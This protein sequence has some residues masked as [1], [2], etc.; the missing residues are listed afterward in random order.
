[1][2]RFKARDQ[3][4]DFSQPTPPSTTPSTCNA[5]SHRERPTGR[6]AR[7]EHMAR[8]FRHGLT[9]SRSA[10]RARPS[11]ENVTT[12]S[13]S[14]DGPAVRS[15]D[16]SSAR[17]TR[18]PERVHTAAARRENPEPCAREL[19][20]ENLLF[21]VV[22][23]ANLEPA[24]GDIQS[25]ADDLTH[26]EKPFAVPVAIDLQPY[27]LDAQ[28]GAVRIISFAAATAQSPCSER[29]RPSA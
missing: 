2:Q 17:K 14:P 26:D 4:K 12:P 23:A 18:L 7:D 16:P 8:G 25:D 13:A 11:L 22:A 24:L 15:R 10:A 3:L 19:S 29:H 5:T 27:T 6:Y 1:M 21:R 20:I 28:A 9:C